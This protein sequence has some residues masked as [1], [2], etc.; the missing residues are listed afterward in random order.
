MKTYVI[1]GATSGIGKALAIEFS[2][3]NRVFAGYR[4]LEKLEELQKSSSNIVPFYINMEDDESIVQAAEFIS[5]NC[6][7]IDTLINAAG[8]VVAGAVENINIDK[9]RAQFNVNTFSH[10]LFTQNLLD[11]L[12]GGKIINISSMA[13]FGIFP[14]V[15]PY[16]A[17]KRALDILFNSMTLEFDRDIKIISVK[18][19]V[20]A[21]P[22]WEKSID[23][24]KETIEKCPQ[25]YETQMKYLV[26]NARKN[27]TKG[28]NV[29]AVVEKIKKIDSL[30]HPKPSYV[31]GKDAM[32]AEI[33]S[34]F[35]QGTLNSL[36]KFGMQAKIGK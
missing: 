15:S 1:T 24:N 17:S 12:E 32:F 19:G 16:C 4:N 26:K 13:S 31:I 7:N 36:I 30:K 21:T 35:P 22:L 10:L 34:K 25:N 29:N 5:Q 23:L 11:K 28:L 27:G 6:Q 20:I 33:I 14:F 3:N 9:I 8:C 2:K 18:P